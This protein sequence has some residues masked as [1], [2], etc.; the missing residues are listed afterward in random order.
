MSA[1]S[2]VS[3]VPSSRALS[4]SA[5]RTL[6]M[7][8]SAAFVAAS[9]APSPL[10]AL[11][12][13]AWGFAPVMVTVVYGVYSV[14]L[15]V[16]LL[17]LGGLSDYVGRRPVI[18]AG[19]ALNLV[20]MAGF[21]VADSVG[22][23]VAA[24]LLQ[25]FASGLIVTTASAMLIDVAGQRGAS[26][27]TASQSLGGGAGALLAAACVQ[28]LPAPL[29]TVYAVLA[30]VLGIQLLLS[31][32]LPDTLAP[33]PGAWQSLR[34]SLAF[35]RRVRKTIALTVPLT[36][37]GWS[38]SAF[39]MSLGPTLMREATGIQSRL[40][41]GLIITVLA[42]SAGLCA[43]FLRGL[44]GLSLLRVAAGLGVTG[45]LVLQV[46]THGAHPV[47]FFAGVL[48]AGLAQGAGVAGVMRV[49]L[50]LAL[51]HERAGV[52]ATLSVIGYMANCVP[53]VVAG[54]LI[55]TFGLMGVARGFMG[56]ML[57]LYVFSLA[58]LRWLPP[59]DATD[60]PT[61]A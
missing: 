47:L 28:Y 5:A 21:L 33:R 60:S 4:L 34:P 55:P 52:A 58:A 15:L 20:A 59:E 23:L 57:V 11:Y 12:R 25:G 31:L 13:E 14:G 45:L 9:A 7:A 29:R 54:A 48:L 35:P 43:F 22:W 27:T 17:V 49:V 56:V 2:H 61:P 38:V 1:V 51:P 18:L 41:D 36:L 24:R 32:R 19:C 42:A 10:Y 37:A 40:A 16:T 30:L 6:L 44:T 46:S 50:R 8:V 26:F 3:P 39:V 53:P